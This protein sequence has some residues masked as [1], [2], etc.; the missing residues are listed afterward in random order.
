MNLEKY[1][2]LAAFV[3]TPDGK[4]PNLWDS[5]RFIDRQTGEEIIISGA[6]KEV[7]GYIFN[8]CQ[9]RYDNPNSRQ[10]YPFDQTWV[11]DSHTKIGNYLG[12]ERRGV[13]RCINDLIEAGLIQQWQPDPNKKQYCYRPSS[14]QEYLGN[15]RGY[16][17]IR[18]MTVKPKN[19]GERLPTDQYHYD[20]FIDWSMDYNS[21]N[22]KPKFE[23]KQDPSP[24][25]AEATQ[26]EVQG[27]PTDFP[28]V[29]DD[30]ENI[31]F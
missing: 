9:S 6:A 29:E 20:H 23:R 11:K 17:I 22:P 1:A 16:V 26:D 4:H 12:T 27:Q 21:S 15:G 14:R 30:F 8:A 7:Y 18:D 31:P 2:D 28:D 24:A 5:H 19:K 10:K 25:Q 3:P 13:A